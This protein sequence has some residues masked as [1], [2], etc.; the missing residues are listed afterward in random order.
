[1][2]SGQCGTCKRSER[3][4]DLK[5]PKKKEVEVGRA[6]QIEGSD[7]SISR[8]IYFVLRRMDR[9]AVLPTFGGWGSFEGRLV[10]PALV[11]FGRDL[12]IF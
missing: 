8:T 5:A 9:E 2:R 10:G 11:C 7:Y 12:P 4:G 1:M 3:E 6:G